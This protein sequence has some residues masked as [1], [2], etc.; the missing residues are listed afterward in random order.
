M[1][2]PLSISVFE[3]VGSAQCVASD[4]GQ[5]VHDRIAAI[6]KEGRQVTVSFQNV[7]SLTSA[8][9]NSAIGQ[10]YGGDFTEEQIRSG[11]KV[12]DLQQDDLVLLKRVVDTAKQYFKD[13]QRFQQAA[14]DALGE[15]EDD[16]K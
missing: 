1:A 8:F 6:L 3:I 2:Q 13:P 12:Q 11:L 14:Q 15:T 5:K 10:L 9:L 7:T 4:D 16:E